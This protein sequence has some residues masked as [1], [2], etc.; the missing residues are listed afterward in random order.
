MQL[1]LVL[2]FLAQIGFSVG[3]FPELIYDHPIV[4]HQDSLEVYR[5]VM[6][7]LVRKE[8]QGCGQPMRESE[9][10][11]MEVSFANSNAEIREFK[12]SAFKS[13]KI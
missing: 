12:V 10:E 4:D 3:V 7:N 1:S 2:L 13:T 11:E 8:G 5:N 9:N 6:E